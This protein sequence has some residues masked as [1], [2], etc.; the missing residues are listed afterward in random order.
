MFMTW[1]DLTS[2]SLYVRLTYPHVCGEVRIKGPKLRLGGRNNHQFSFIED[3]GVAN[4]C[5]W[6][7]ASP[8]DAQLDSNIWP[9]G[10]SGFW[11][12]WKSAARLLQVSSFTLVL[13]GLR[14]RGVTHHF[15]TC[16]VGLL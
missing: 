2:A 10:A 13:A 3:P 5:D 1:R 12:C 14:A 11:P 8:N 7:T 6:L 4:C 15:L 16:F 9:T